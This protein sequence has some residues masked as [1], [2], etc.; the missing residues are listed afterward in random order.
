M[1]RFCY[2]DAHCDTVHACFIRGSAMRRNDGQVDLE[3]GGA[4][5]RWAQVFALYENRA[6]VSE[7]SMFNLLKREYAFFQ[8]EMANN[9]DLVTHCRTAAEVETANASGKIAAILS[10][11][12]AE[13]LD[14]A[15]E[16]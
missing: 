6:N 8:D 15:P 11:E 13:L 2:F 16:N 12:G 7:C 14:C 5:A 3:R 4:F 9:A 10:I 1:D